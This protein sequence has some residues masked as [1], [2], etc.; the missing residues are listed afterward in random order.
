MRLDDEVYDECIEKIRKTMNFYGHQNREMADDILSDVSTPISRPLQ[1]TIRTQQAEIE[2]LKGRHNADDKRISDLLA[3]FKAKDDA[4]KEGINDMAVSIGIVMLNGGMPTKEHTDKV[5]EISTPDSDIG[6]MKKALALQPN[7]VELVEV[8]YGYV[9]DDGGI[10]GIER[11]EIPPFY[12]EKL[13]TI[14][15]KE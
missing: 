8:G 1:E 3:V 15:T 7:D 13:Y 5:I 9:D 10:S 12:T 6:K 11:I 2:R 4:L 14:K